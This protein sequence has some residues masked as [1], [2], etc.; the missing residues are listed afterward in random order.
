MADEKILIE[1]DGNTASISKGGQQLPLTDADKES[2]RKILGL[3]GETLGEV[4][5][6]GPREMWDGM[7]TA[8]RTAFK[9]FAAVAGVGSAVG[10]GCLA[11][12][13]FNEGKITKKVLKACGRGGESEATGL[14]EPAPGGSS[15]SS[16]FSSVK[17]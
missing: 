13:K 2:L 8:G 15:E 7:S 9:I 6:A 3:N 11:D 5:G 12:Q 4:S 14:I 1:V 10:L 16:P 17:L